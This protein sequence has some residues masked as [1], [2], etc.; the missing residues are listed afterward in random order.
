M[1]FNNGFPTN[2][3]EGEEC[4]EAAAAEGAG[5]PCK[6]AGYR[7]QNWDE[8]WETF[9]TFRVRLPRKYIGGGLFSL[10]NGRTILASLTGNGEDN[11]KVLEI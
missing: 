10:F 11:F 4:D 8:V 5:N 6:P 2:C 7:K 1:F 3:I 9:V